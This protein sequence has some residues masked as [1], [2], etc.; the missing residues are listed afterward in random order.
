MNNGFNGGSAVEKDNLGRVRHTIDDVRSEADKVDWN[1]ALL[2]QSE[3]QQM[4]N[5]MRAFDEMRDVRDR[6]EADRLGKAIDADDMIAAA[7]SSTPRGETLS[8][9]QIN[10]MNRSRGKES[11]DGSPVDGQIVGGGWNPKTGGFVFST[12]QVNEDGSVTEV[13]HEYTSREVYGMMRN[14]PGYFNDDEREGR[15]KD[16][17]DYARTLDKSLSDDVFEQ[18][19]TS[20]SGRYR[21]MKERIDEIKSRLDSRRSGGLTFDQRKELSNMVTDRQDKLIKS[22]KDISDQTSRNQQARL[23][24]SVSK[25]VRDILRN[26]KM[27]DEEKNTLTDSL[28]KTL[29][30]AFGGGVEPG[31]GGDKPN[32]A[33]IKPGDNSGG[34]E[35][36]GNLTP[37]QIKRFKEKGGRFDEKT[38]EVIMPSGRKMKVASAKRAKRTDDEIANDPQDGDTIVLADGTTARFGAKANKWSLV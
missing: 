18:F 9:G 31:S 29:L 24:A 21:K 6:E 11:R 28:T 2:R 37:D 19:A 10:L 30:G 14:H 3:E 36:W 23:A 8:S 33:E 7:I 32:Q 25:D 5:G 20:A 17:R 15:M 34:D 22:K 26:L 4:L 1:K 13:P 35:K 38:N 16:Y 12:A 27:S